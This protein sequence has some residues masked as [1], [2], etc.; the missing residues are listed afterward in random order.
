[1]VYQTLQYA[2]VI[3]RVYLIQLYDVDIVEFRTRMLVHG[4]EL[5]YIVKG[6]WAPVRPVCSAPIGY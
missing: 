4:I 1:M 6:Q 2:L 5:L 3:L